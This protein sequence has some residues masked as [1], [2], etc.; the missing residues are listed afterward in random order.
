MLMLRI[1][2]NNHNW[3]QSPEKVTKLGMEE[4][5]MG[6]YLPRGGYPDKATFQA[7]GLKK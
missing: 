3:E 4:G 5:F 6:P 2:A 1:M 7:S